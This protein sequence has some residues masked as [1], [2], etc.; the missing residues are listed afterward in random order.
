[1]NHERAVEKQRKRRRNHVRR[2]VRGTAERPRLSV[3][4]SHCHIYAQVIDDLAGRTLAS[5][6]S[7]DK[8]L[9]EQ[10]S[11]GGNK[12]AATTVGKTLAERA[13]AAGVKKV[14]FDRGSFQYHGRIAALADAAR[15]AGLSF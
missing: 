1:M 11:Y 8:Q 4:R 15:E 14:A 7:R 3:H 2:I 6:S 12:Q 5:A 9:R 13:L 10:V